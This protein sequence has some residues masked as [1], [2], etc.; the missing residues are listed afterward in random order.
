MS[1][2]VYTISVKLYGR[3]GKKLMHEEIPLPKE[4]SV[5]EAVQVFK[6]TVDVVKEPPP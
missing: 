3:N 5:E 1:D 6:D 4:F 2:D